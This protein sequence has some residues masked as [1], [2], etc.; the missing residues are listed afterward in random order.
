VLRRGLLVAALA[1][2]GWLLSVLFATSAAATDEPTGTPPPAAGQPDQEPAD[3]PAQ[4]PAADDPAGQ[5]SEPPAEDPAADPTEDPTDDPVTD[6]GADPVEEPAGPSTDPATD[7]VE[8]PVGEP[9]G[10]PADERPQLLAGS[11][12]SGGQFGELLSGV[13]DTAQHVTHTV[14]AT[15]STVLSGTTHALVPAGQIFAWPDLG[16]PGSAAPAAP[17]GPTGAERAAARPAPRAPPVAPATPAATRTMPAQPSHPVAAHRTSGEPDRTHGGANGPA[18]ERA[19]R[20]ARD[21]PVKTPTAPVAPGTSVSGAHDGP[22]TARGIHGVLT[23][24]ATFTPEAAGYTTRSRAA[25]VT[26]RVSGL[27]ATSP[28]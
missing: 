19:D 17:A 28:D 24:Q 21:E 7:P 22:G 2:A 13:A 27:P 12:Q 5:P 25:D 9:A 20:P 15:T 3:Q 10:G 6:P 1:A 18:G 23:G 8:E 11:A 16:L 26:G 4:D 14:T